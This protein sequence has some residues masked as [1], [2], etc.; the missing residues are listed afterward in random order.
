[1]ARSEAKSV[2]RESTFHVDLET[3]DAL[4]TELVRLVTR[5]CHDL[6]SDGLRART[7]TVK[8]RDFDFRT[9]QASRTL[10]TAVS[11]DRA[12]LP[13]ARAL[14][15]RLRE[16]RRTGARL[17]G[18]GFTQLSPGELPVQ[19][20]LFPEAT[21]SPESARDRAVA[22]TVDRIQERFGSQA[23]RPALLANPPAHRGM[24]EADE[25]G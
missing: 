1:M 2:S 12:V 21:V 4:E 24:I 17:L 11:T 19:L 22:R 10:D 8:L 3:D 14:L 13:V 20:G 5:V 15:Q 6:R 25:T 23:I 18:V 7:I 16:E 9:R